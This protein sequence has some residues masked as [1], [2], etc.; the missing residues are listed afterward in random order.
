MR[1]PSLQPFSPSGTISMSFGPSSSTSGRRQAEA[2]SVFN[3]IRISP[4]WLRKASGMSSRPSPSPRKTSAVY[5][6]YLLA[7]YRMDGDKGRPNMV[8][9]VAATSPAARTI[10]RT[11]NSFGFGSNITVD[12]SVS[13]EATLILEEMEGMAKAI[14]KRDSAHSTLHDQYGGPS[15]KPSERG[16]AGGILPG[17]E[18]KAVGEK[19]A[20][21]SILI[22]S[23]ANGTK[24]KVTQAKTYEEKVC[25]SDAICQARRRST[26]P[27]SRP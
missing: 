20:T 23:E 8:I 26:I 9:K 7:G 1:S 13:Q 19:G 2:W 5:D 17:V 14:R 12:Y 15:R 11:I 22:L 24:E 18:K 21:E 27:Y 10:T 16:Q 4:T 3:S 6:R 25:G